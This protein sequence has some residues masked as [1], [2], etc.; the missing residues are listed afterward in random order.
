MALASFI[1]GYEFVTTECPGPCSSPPVHQRT[2]NPRMDVSVTPKLV[3]DA[4]STRSVTPDRSRSDSAP[5]GAPPAPT[6]T[7]PESAA[8]A[9]TATTATSP[10]VTSPAPTS[11]PRPAATPDPAP[12]GADAVPASGPQ[13]LAAAPER[14][15]V[16]VATAPSLRRPTGTALDAINEVTANIVFVVADSGPI[17]IDHGGEW[18]LVRPPLGWTAP[19]RRTI[20]INPDHPASQIDSALADVIVHELGH[21]LIST[22]HVSDGTILDP[23]IDGRIVIGPQDRAY[24]SELTC[25]DL[26]L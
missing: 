7:A 24:L 3:T 20:L 19:D 26:G 9:V 25:G 10:P 14:C 4:V 23:N 16:A 17:S 12:S 2:A 5:D 11:S 1:G 6:T 13:P 18:P 8:P 21:V 15:P 22:A